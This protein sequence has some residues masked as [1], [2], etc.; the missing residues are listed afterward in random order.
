VEESL[1]EANVVIREAG[2]ADI[3]KLEVVLTQA[4]LS[5]NDLL[6]AETRY[7]LAEDGEK[8]P[9]G[10]VGLELGSSAVLL[11]ST[12][13]S[14]SWRGRGVGTS[15]VQHALGAASK[16]QRV[17]LFSTGAGAYWHHLGFRKV[18]VSELVA[19]F[20]EA[21]Q[22]KQYERLGWLSTEVAWRYDVVR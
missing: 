1:R 21:P 20:P 16:Y 11:R 8:Q 14:P 12:A 7:W 5:A 10:V 18:P 9:V 13:V 3:T 15:L 6:A 17:Y 4:G 2:L 22:V 19:A